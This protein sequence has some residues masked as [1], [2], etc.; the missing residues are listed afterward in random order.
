MNYYRQF[1]LSNPPFE[2]V[3]QPNSLY[4]SKAHREGL[5]ALEWGL[6]HEPGHFTLLMGQAGTGKTTLIN[7]LLSRHFQCIAN[8]DGHAIYSIRTSDLARIA[9][10]MNPKL[11]FEEMLRVVLEQLGYPPS[12]TTKLEL[13]RKFEWLFG[14]LRPR[15]RIAIII[16]EA[17]ALSDE[18]LED[19]RL[20]SNYSERGKGHLEILLVGQPEL[21]TR[22]ME[23]SLR[24]F[25]QRIGARAILNP[26]QRDEAFEYIEHKLRESGGSTKKI[27]GKRALQLL[28]DHSQGI[29]RQLNLLCNNALIRAYGSDLR[30]VTVK[31]AREAIREFENLSGTEEEFREPIGRLALHS[32]TSYAAIS[33]AGFSL[34]AVLGLSSLGVTI[35]AIRLVI[36]EVLNTNLT[37]YPKTSLNDTSHNAVP[38]I[39]APEGSISDAAD[40]RSPANDPIVHPTQQLA[41]NGAAKRLADDDVA[42]SPGSTPSVSVVN[43]DR[44]AQSKSREAVAYEVQEGDTI[45]GIALHHFGSTVQSLQA[46][47]P[48]LRDVNRIY[49]GD[50][51]FP[52]AV[53]ALQPRSG[54]DLS[55]GLKRARTEAPVRSQ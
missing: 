11:G 14:E 25:H 51:I 49:P 54:N 19:L 21:L 13:L 34:I 10:V 12:A 35:P 24:Q 29:P 50:T 16:D 3:S 48:Q 6:L 7:V 44:G 37:P 15:E 47:N 23:P 26:L 1:G 18:T 42:S 41:N 28:V 5:A 46:A 45:E 2:M 43:P 20:F 53:S 33:L 38:T 8:A 4:M 32:I 52:P 36:S 39:K 22:L 55:G 31:V 30:I 17:Q 9:Y 40:G 27:F